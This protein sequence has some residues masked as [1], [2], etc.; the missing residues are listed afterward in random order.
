MKFTDIPKFTRTPTYHVDVDLDD[1]K[2]WLD[3]RKTMFLELNPDFQRGHV[4]SKKQQT[5]YMEYLLR[6]G[7]SGR[8]IYLNHPGW[9]IDWKG[10]FVCVD[11]LQRLT[12]CLKFLADEVPVFGLL[13]SEFEDSVPFTDVSLSIWINN[14]KTR[15]EVLTWYL[16]MNTGGTIHTDREIEKVKNLLLIEMKE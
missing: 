1:L 15:K 4:W 3:K 6:G 16:E 9:M 10:D 8:E 14:L 7:S 11:G 5:A 13:C 12:A 2:A